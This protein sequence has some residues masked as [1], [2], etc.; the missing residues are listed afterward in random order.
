MRNAVIL[1]PCV[2]AL[3]L[4]PSSNFSAADSLI[5]EVK[6]VIDVVTVLWNRIA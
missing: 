6:A 2:C 4:L 1:L 3:E 5:V